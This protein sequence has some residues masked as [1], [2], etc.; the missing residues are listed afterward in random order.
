MDDYRDRLYSSYV[1][2]LYGKVN[3][4]NLSN[5]HLESYRLEFL[6]L[7]PDD[8]GAP[9]L[10]AGCGAGLL[11][12]ALH[13]WGY[14]DLEGIDASDE[15]VAICLRKGLHVTK[16]H[17]VPHLLSRPN[18]YGAII[19]TD[20]IEHLTKEEL[21]TFFEAAHESLQQRGALLVR[22]INAAGG[23]GG[24][25]RYCDLTHQTSF[26]EISM[27]QLFNATGFGKVAIRDCKVPFGWRPRRFVRWFVWKIVYFLRRLALMAEMGVDAPRCLGK[28]LIGKGE[29]A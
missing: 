27:L 11:L 18:H 29:K 5:A 28:L 1:S 22:T 19:C 3:D 13:A 15:Q 26:T 20:V 23:S 16:G 14:R 17:I 2:D 21:L 4:L 12:E 10:D 6:D 25:S 8:K 9:I 7:L 24:I